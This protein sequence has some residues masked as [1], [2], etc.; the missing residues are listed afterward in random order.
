MAAADGHA[1]VGMDFSENMLAKAREKDTRDQIRWVAASADRLPFSD[2]S[3]GCI[4]SAFALRNLRACLDKAFQENFRGLKNDG[5]VLHLDFG[6]PD[7]GSFRWGHQ[8]HMS[9]GV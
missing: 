6:R 2:Q 1:V 7:P 9:I 5:R 4:T 3:F 8:L